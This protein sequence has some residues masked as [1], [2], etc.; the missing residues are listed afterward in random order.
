MKGFS[1]YCRPPLLG[2]SW[3]NVR[4]VFPSTAGRLAYQ[5]RPSRHV[6]QLKPAPGLRW[7][8]TRLFL[9]FFHTLFVML[10]PP[11]RHIAISPHG[12]LYA[13]PSLCGS[14][15]ATREWFRAFTAHSFLTCRPLRPRGVRHRY[16]SRTFDAD[17]GLR[18]MTTGSALPT[19]PQSVPRGRSIS[20]LHWF[21]SATACQGARPPVRIRLERPAFGDFYL[22]AFNGSVSLSVA[23]Y[24]YNSD[25]T[26]LLAG[27][28]PAGMA[29]SLA[30]QSFKPRVQPFQ[31]NAGVRCC[32]LPVCLGVMLVAI[33]LPSGDFSG[34]SLFVWNAA[35]QTLGRENAE[36]GLRH[37]EP[38]AVLRRVMPFEAFDE[39][40]RLVGRKG[41]I[42]RGGLVGAEIILT[43]H[44][45]RR[46]GHPE[47][48]IT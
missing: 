46:A 43:Q 37:V 36:F 20:W 16:P 32:E 30:A 9:P 26:P 4:R 29:A 47:T 19:L 31:L 34:E 33:V 41:F 39:A 6:I 23:G 48:W 8:T 25:W 35:I 12:G 10:R 14:A 45:P 27:L 17:I 13:M 44:D 7:S 21:A 22:Q 24:N 15:E 5:A 38:A 3:R 11:R 2:F 1:S 18:R 40:A 42:E 28:S